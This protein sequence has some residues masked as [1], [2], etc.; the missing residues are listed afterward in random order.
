MLL[1]ELVEQVKSKGKPFDLNEP[2]YWVL[3]H[4]SLPVNC[5]GCFPILH[6]DGVFTNHL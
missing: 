4:A 6:I 3:L 5:N 2:K 1:R